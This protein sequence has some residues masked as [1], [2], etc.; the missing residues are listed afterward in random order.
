M[1]NIRCLQQKKEKREK[2]REKKR[3]SSIVRLSYIHKCLWL[4]L[5]LERELCPSA[6]SILFLH[7]PLRQEC[8]WLIRFISKPQTKPSF[9]LISHLLLFGIGTPI[10]IICLFSLGTSISRL[11]CC[12]LLGAVLLT[13]REQGC[14]SEHPASRATALPWSPTKEENS[15]PSQG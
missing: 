7:S 12:W 13:E 1:K 9:P 3:G 15:S 5:L 14:P 4:G 11:C 10:N 6:G 2:G 8:S